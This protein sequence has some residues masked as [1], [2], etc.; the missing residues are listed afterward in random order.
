MEKRNAGKLIASTNKETDD[1]TETENQLESD[2]RPDEQTSPV[3]ENKSHCE[4]VSVDPADEMTPWNEIQFPLTNTNDLTYLNHLLGTNS[5]FRREFIDIFTNIKYLPNNRT[6]FDFAF[7]VTDN[8]FDREL[9]F[10]YSWSGHSPSPKVR[11]LP[12]K[13]FTEILRAFYEILSTRNKKYSRAMTLYYLKNVMFRRASVNAKRYV[14]YCFILFIKIYTCII[15][16]SLRVL[17]DY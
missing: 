8:I 11:K 4:M 6:R 1:K 14:P 5:E 10:K 7:A 9:L 17:F 3:T 13:N 2:K 12:F 15:T 16:S